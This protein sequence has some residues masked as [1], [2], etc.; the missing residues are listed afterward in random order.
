MTQKEKL[1]LEQEKAKKLENL[2]IYEW[3]KKN[4]QEL[5][6]KDEDIFKEYKKDSIYASR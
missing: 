4:D 1:Y 5:L 2:T 3:L 6:K